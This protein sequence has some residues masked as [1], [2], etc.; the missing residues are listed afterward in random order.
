M[1]ILP[2]TKDATNLGPYFF[3]HEYAAGKFLRLRHMNG[4]GLFDAKRWDT[5]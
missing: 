1:L 4:K 2:T 5:A 3:L